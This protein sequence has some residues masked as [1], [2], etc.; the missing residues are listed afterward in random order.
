MARRPLEIGPAHWAGGAALGLAL[1]LALGTFA[2]ILWQA[3][4]PAQLAGRLTAADWAAARFTLWQALWSAALSTLLAVPVARALARRDF[5]GRR[6]MIAALGAPFILPV[7][8]AVMGLLAVFGRS[9]I[10]NA[11]LQALGL[12]GFSPYG[13]GGI[14]MAHVFLNL[15]LAVRMILNGWAAIPAERFRLAASLGFGPRQVWR[16]IERPMLRAILPGAA[17]AIFLICL[18]SFT[19]VLVMGGGPRATT[20][21]LA[22]Y[23]SFRMEFDLP[24]ASALA[25]LQMVLSL[26]A[27]G[28][29]LALSAPSGF[30]AGLGRGPVARWDAMGPGTRLTDV[31]VLVLTGLFLA[32]P[33]IFVLVMGL[34]ALPA[35]PG[36]VWLA[37]LRSL[38]VA[39]MAAALALAL[40]LSIACLVTG[41]S[42]RRGRVVDALAMLT[43]SASP[44]V[45]G[46]GLFLI[47]RNRAEPTAIALPVIILVNALMAMPFCLRILAPG[48]QSLRADYDRLSASLGL[49]GWRWLRLVALP[50]LRRPLAF[51][52]GLAAALSAGDLGVVTLFADPSRATLPMQIFTLAGAYRMGQAAAATLVLMALAFGLFRAIDRLGDH[53]AD[54]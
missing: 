26:I 46:T 39:L 23:Q 50:R 25:G 10:V 45:I 9:G 36:A 11:A 18:S 37:A 4:G 5:R 42:P 33:L 24:H 7:I 19:V 15:P 13:L 49:T 32:V 34:P 8:A 38:L 53:D 41:L 16:F 6:L 31:T 12:P 17:L 27:T 20:L 40:G 2:A 1:A 21:E 43:I 52:G 44:L 28:M 22:I 51:A 30:G 3:G 14:L 29:A 54:L 48:L 47:L 35:L